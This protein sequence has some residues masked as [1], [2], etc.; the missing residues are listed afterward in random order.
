MDGGPLI[1]MFDIDIDI[2]ELADPLWAFQGNSGHMGTNHRFKVDF[3][4]AQSTVGVG[5]EMGTFS[6]LFS[7]IEFILL[8]LWPVVSANF[9]FLKTFIAIS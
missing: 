7:R 2:A 6:K 5:D 1:K 3:L 4:V 8:A 9:K